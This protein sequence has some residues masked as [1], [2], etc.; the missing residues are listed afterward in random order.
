MIVGFGKRLAMGCLLAFTVGCNE[1]PKDGAAPP[2]ASST[3][4][5]T[6]GSAAEAGAP[7]SDARWYPSGDNQELRLTWAIYPATA[8]EDLRGPK[9]M[10]EIIARVG[11]AT[12]RLKLGTYNGILSPSNQSLCTPSLKKG[13]V[14]S[15]IGLTTTGPRTLY[16]KRTAPDKLEISF[17]VDADPEENGV[18]G[19]IPIPAGASITEAISDIR[20]STQEAPFDCKGPD[21]DGLPKADPLTVSQS[22]KAVDTQDWQASKPGSKLTA[23]WTVDQS[24]ATPKIVG[25][26]DAPQLDRTKVS[27][28]VTLQ[29]SLGGRSHQVNAVINAA[30]PIAGTCGTLSTWFAHVSVALEL[31]RAANGKV[32]LERKEDF[33]KLKTEQ[34]YVFDVPSNVSVEQSVFVIDPQGKREKLSEKCKPSTL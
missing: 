33:P 1:K 15:Q 27:V 31:K 4:N 13:D 10:I 6:T 34:L 11:S 22:A 28:P 16:A 21:S 19:T 8:N 9:R 12:K 30:P 32:V 17:H 24:H 3:A 7:D 18:L 20:S 14:V 5:G 23:T 25:K 2:A 29:L 26:I